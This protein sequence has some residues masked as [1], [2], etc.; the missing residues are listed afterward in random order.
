MEL[1]PHDDFPY[2]QGFMPLYV[3]ATSDP[4]FQ[5]GYY[6][7]FYRPG[8]HVFCGLRLHPNTNVMDAYAGLAV[9]GEQRNVRMSRA[10]MPRHGELSVGP[11]TIHI[12]E[13]M[14]RQRLVLEDNPTGLTFDVEFTSDVPAS[15]EHIPA[16]YRYGRLFNQ[17]LR[18]SQTNRARGT[19]TVDGTRH[20]V[21][22]FGCRDHSWGIRSTFGPHVPIGGLDQRPTDPRSI[23]L[24]VPFDVGDHAGFFHGHADRDG[25]TL[26]FE[27]QIFL[28]DR[29]VDLLACH[30][31]LE[32]HEGTRRVRGGSFTLVDTEGDEHR[33][34]FE[35]STAVHPQGFGYT[36]GWSDGGQHGV[37]RGAEVM[38][39]DRF[40]IDDPT[41]VLGPQHV[42]P[43]RRLGPCE[44]ASTFTHADTGARGMAHVEHMVYGDHRPTAG[45]L[46]RDRVPVG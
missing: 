21:D 31:D 16:Q 8:Q 3:P 38:E 22:D 14:V 35:V 45:V 27:G 43:H 40:R 18:Y 17:V 2:H 34:R 24:W 41:Q 28:P 37:Y 12:V 19:M 13:P 20:E 15:V 5:D 6:F 30:H 33:Y 9:D 39:D 29:T 32:Y 46:Q 25:G 42:P 7:A 26:D 4:H 23:R 11:L 44:F 10:L 1:T 36:R